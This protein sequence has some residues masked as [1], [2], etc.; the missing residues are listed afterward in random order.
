MLAFNKHFLLWFMSL[1]LMPIPRND[2]REIYQVQWRLRQASMITEANMAVSEPAL[3][4]P[5]LPP[6]FLYCYC[7]VNHLNGDRKRRI[8]V[9]VRFH[10]RMNF[11]EYRFNIL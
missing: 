2:I 6:H 11:R 8:I 10:T 1:L 9:V 3:F 4:P 5:E 7:S